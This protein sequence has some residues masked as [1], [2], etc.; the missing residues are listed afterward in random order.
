MEGVVLSRRRGTSNGDVGDA[1]W[2]YIG[3][4]GARVPAADPPSFGRGPGI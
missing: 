3:S 2:R 1:V 4:A